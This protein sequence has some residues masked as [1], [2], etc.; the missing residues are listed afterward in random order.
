MAK[1]IFV[2]DLEF[3]EIKANLKEF[4]SSQT[5]FSDYNF[6]GS[7]LS[8]LLDVLAYNTHY[9]A[10]YDNMLVNESFLDSATKRESVVS[11]AADLGYTPRSAKCSKMYINLV[12]TIVGNPEN[13]PAQISVPAFSPFKSNTASASYTFYNP[14]VIVL[15]KTGNQYVANN[16]LLLG[17]KPFK[18]SYTY[19]TAS[20]RFVIPNQGCD[21]DTIRVLVFDSGSQNSRN[22]T[23]VRSNTI[24]DVKSD[25]KVYW[26]KEIDNFLYEMKFGDGVIGKALTSGNLVVVDYMTAYGSQSNGIR[27]VVYSG[28]KTFTYLGSLELTVSVSVS[29]ALTPSYGGDEI[30]SVESIKFNA[31]RSFSAQNRAVT[32]DD[33]KTIILSNFPEAK[34]VA[35][36]GGEDNYPPEYGK[37]FICVSQNNFSKLTSNQKT[38]ILN[39]LRNRKVVSVTPV[40]LDT[41]YIEL[42][43]DV[44]VYY[45]ERET[46]RSISDI[47]EIVLETIY[48][49]NDS[50]LEKFDG[51][52]RYSKLTRE[53]DNS[54]RA[55]INTNIN[56]KMQRSIFPKYNVSAEYLINLIN[57]I[58]PGT[59]NTTG[60]YIDLDENEYF[61]D[62]DGLGNVRLYYFTQSS[63]K[64]IRNDSIG[65]IDYVNG[66]ITVSGLNV[67]AVTN[68]S[69]TMYMEPS[70]KDVVS[71][72]NQIV[73]ILDDKISI[74]VYADKTAIGDLRAGRNY[75]FS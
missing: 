24:I 21:V 11:R 57:P 8:V 65:K 42:Q 59:F 20:T 25:S 73:R 38:E 43:L 58:K 45:N 37:V 49:Y 4:L 56:L 3:D 13:P 23:Y 27:S 48:A 29:N 12:F 31:P 63:E 46:T 9:N 32:V 67:V 64:I 35:V 68:T 71:A 41:E 19:D 14:Q 47:R 52:F 10:L 28:T 34:S 55:I 70:S 53:I 6:E 44:S 17:G 69:I 33:Y 61:L 72:L 36:W 26:V 66:L 30:E 50:D 51:V 1:K 75:N 22:E 7:G 15:T 62:D 18:F 60:F 16:V 40:I 5:E 2:S 74:N 54:D 39:I